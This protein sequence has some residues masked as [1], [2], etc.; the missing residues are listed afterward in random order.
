[1]KTIKLDKTRYGKDKIPKFHL[2]FRLSQ[3]NCCCKLL[4]RVLYKRERIKRGIDISP[5]TNI[6]GGVYFGHPYGITINPQAIIGYNVNIHKG[7][8]IG[9]EN[10]GERIGAPQIGNYV[11]IGVNA[12][13]VGNVTIGDDVLIAP[14][15]FI[16]FDV[17]SHSI[18]IGNPGR[19]V[20][21]M[22]ATEG[23]INNTISIS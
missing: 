5:E 7:V 19:I 10:R 14:N 16:N 4:F 23:Y 2:L 20:Y 3:C 12:T 1:M 21:R 15:S 17:P 9:R 11:W 18:V 6:G 8:T 22:N 13:V